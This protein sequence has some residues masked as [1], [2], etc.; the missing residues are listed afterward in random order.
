MPFSF[1]G[2]KVIFSKSSLAIYQFLLY[3]FFSLRYFMFSVIGKSLNKFFSIYKNLCLYKFIS[4]KH[5][6]TNLSKVNLEIL[7]NFSTIFRSSNQRYSMKKLFLVFFML[8]FM[9][10][11]LLKRDS[12][13]CFLVNIAKFLRTPILENIWQR[14]LLHFWKVFPKNLFSVNLYILIIQTVFRL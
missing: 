7:R 3:Q 10:S 1:S 2:L 8:A 9:P 13:T 12:N 6:C 4:Y 11:T 5:F 14:L